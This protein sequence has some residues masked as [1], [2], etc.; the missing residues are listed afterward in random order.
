MEVSWWRKESSSRH[1]TLCFLGFP[2][3]PLICL[4]SGLQS[5]CKRTIGC[6]GTGYF[7]S[8]IVASYHSGTYRNSNLALSHGWLDSENKQELV[9]NFV[10]EMKLGVY[11]YPLSSSCRKLPVC[12]D[13]IEMKN[14]IATLNI[15]TLTSA[16]DVM[17][18]SQYWGEAASIQS[19]RIR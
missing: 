11:I 16:L 6:R 9:T 14:N 15:Y 1:R 2:R 13:Y 5:L 18:S 10:I 7:L 3:S 4:Y 12:N 19:N 8:G 17:G